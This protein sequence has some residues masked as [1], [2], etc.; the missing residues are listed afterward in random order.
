MA[1]SAHARASAG[2]SGAAAWGGVG[3]VGITIG[4]LSQH[5]NRCKGFLWVAARFPPR[6][7]RLSGSCFSQRVSVDA[8]VRV[9]VGQAE[10]FVDLGD[11]GWGQ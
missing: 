5:K 8:E 11:D 1:F 2:W 6:R 3:G 7:L 10:Q 9:G 4:K